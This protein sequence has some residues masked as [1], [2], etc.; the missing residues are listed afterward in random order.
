MVAGAL[1]S[2]ADSL[3]TNRTRSDLTHIESETWRGT[4]RENANM[5][6][7]MARVACK[8]DTVN[9]TIT[10]GYKA[11]NPALEDLVLHMDRV[12]GGVKAYAVFHGMKQRCGD[13]GADDKDLVARRASQEKLV[14]YYESGTESWEQPRV[15]VAPKFDSG[16]AVAALA[17]VKFAGDIDKANLAADRLATAR[18]I[19]R[20][21]ALK[22]FA[23]DKDVAAEIARAKA[24]AT[25]VAFDADAEIAKIMAEESGEPEAA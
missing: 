15:Y 25:P 14:S 17:R 1:H 4:S 10:W 5:E 8:I 9:G 24:S 22:L 16:A 6:A 12:S 11:A 20:D 19:A 21:D 18:N 13:G 23:A 2:V 3:G 7:H